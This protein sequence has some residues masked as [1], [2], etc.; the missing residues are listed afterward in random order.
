[1][2]NGRSAGQKG[3][4]GRD[5][6]GF[7]ALP[8]SVLDCAAYARL[9]HPARALLMEFAR[10]F[11]RDNNGRLLCSMNY[12]RKRGWTSADV[13]TRAKKQLIEYGFIFETVKGRLPNRAAWYAVT[14]RTLDAHPDYD[15]G[16]HVGFERGSYAKQPE[17]KNALPIPRDG[18]RK[19][20]I[21]PAGGTTASLAV[22]SRGAVQCQSHGGPAPAHGN[23]LEMP[24]TVGGCRHVAVA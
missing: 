24:S 13:V 20:P 8:W 18:T 15:P 17:P 4:R 11:V 1:M 14:W 23:H 6:G 16:A 9:S 7:V 5:A 2:A 10:Q 19:R 21:A 12:L 22:P 3:D